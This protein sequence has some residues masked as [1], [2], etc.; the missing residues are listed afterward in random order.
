MLDSKDVGSK[1]GEYGGDDGDVG[2]AG[3]VISDGSEAGIE[4]GGGVRRRRR[5]EKMNR[6]F[7]ASVN[8]DGGAGGSWR[9]QRRR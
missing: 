4:A 1:V 9:G 7:V 6:E 2:D 8:D 3:D 5:L